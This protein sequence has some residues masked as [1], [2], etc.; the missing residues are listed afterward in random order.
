M[1]PNE[2]ELKRRYWMECKRSCREKTE[3]MRDKAEN[4]TCEHREGSR[5]RLARTGEG[6]WGGSEVP[7]QAL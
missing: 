5:E 2:L 1:V 4:F 6:A 7:G 3:G